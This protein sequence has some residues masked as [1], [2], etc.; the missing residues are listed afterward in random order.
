MDDGFFYFAIVAFISGTTILY[1]DIPYI[2]LQENVEAGLRA[3][4][5]NLIAQ[6]IHSIKLQ[7]SANLLLAATILSVKFSFLFFFRTLIRQQKK[8][9]LWWWCI[10]MLVIATTPVLLFSSFISCPYFDERIVG[11]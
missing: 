8:M 1:F 10:V 9:I 4:P 5:A 7:A 2:Y 3:P 11:W 6:L